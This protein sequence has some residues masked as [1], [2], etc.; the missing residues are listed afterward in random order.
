MMLDISS[1]SWWSSKLFHSPA[2]SSHLPMLTWQASYTGGDMRQEGASP[3]CH[4]ALGLGCPTG[5]KFLMAVKLHGTKNDEKAQTNT[6]FW[7]F[8]SHVLSFAWFL[9]LWSYL[10]TLC[11]T[12]K[13]ATAETTTRKTQKIQKED[14]IHPFSHVLMYSIPNIGVSWCVGICIFSCIIMRRRHMVS[15]HKLHA[16]CIISD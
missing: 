8:V 16:W 6:S 13:A 15:L 3:Y 9:F 1:D 7:T 12:R 14:P 2:I 11:K 5:Q 10:S 4:L